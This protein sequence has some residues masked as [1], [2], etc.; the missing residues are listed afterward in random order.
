MGF[1]EALIE[2]GLSLTYHLMIQNRQEKR[3]VHRRIFHHDDHSYHGPGSIRIHI[4]MIFK[5]L[6]QGKEKL[7][8]TTPEIDIIN[9]MTINSIR[10]GINPTKAVSNENN[11]L[12][13]MDFF[14]GSAKG[15]GVHTTNI[16]HGDNQI[17]G[18]PSHNFKGFTT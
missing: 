8:L 1:I 12:G 3:S 9:G 16:G 2:Y 11:L 17:K 6:D 7:R 10:E 5:I 18:L 13:R 14:N 15:K 4:D